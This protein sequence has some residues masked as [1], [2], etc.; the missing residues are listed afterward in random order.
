VPKSRPHAGQAYHS[1][2]FS[3][4]D[5]LTKPQG[6]RM[7]GG[8]SAHA[9]HLK[10]DFCPPAEIKSPRPHAGQ[11]Y[12][13]TVFSEKEV[14]EVKQGI[15]RSES[16]NKSSF[17]PGFSLPEGDS[18][19]FQRRSRTSLS[20]SMSGKLGPDMCSV[21]ETHLRVSPHAAKLTQSH[22]HLIFSPVK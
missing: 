21:E 22:E 18:S 14:P 1:T 2:V 11:A 17:G 20:G 4:E 13:S 9:G 16:A 6:I 10:S 7:S 15:K 3:E 12:H 8:G 5:A 19:Y